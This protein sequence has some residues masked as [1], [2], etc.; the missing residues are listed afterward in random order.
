[1]KK[2]NKMENTDLLLTRSIGIEGIITTYN[3]KDILG[4]NLIRQSFNET[5]LEIKASMKKKIFSRSKK[6]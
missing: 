1:M 2:R 6:V 3:N 4:F 5:G